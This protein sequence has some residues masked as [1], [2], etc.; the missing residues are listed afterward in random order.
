MLGERDKHMSEEA[1]S[2]LESKEAATKFAF[3]ISPLK[4]INGSL[5]LMCSSLCMVLLLCARMMRLPT[6][7]FGKCVLSHT[8][9]QVV[10]C[11]QQVY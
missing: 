10:S 2:S 6:S 3:S 9:D 5:A 1:S 4:Q 11:V 8:M 7:D